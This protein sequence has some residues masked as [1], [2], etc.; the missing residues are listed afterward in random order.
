[1]MRNQIP[2]RDELLSILVEHLKCVI[3]ELPFEIDEIS[4]EKS[5]P[6]SF[7]RLESVYRI[8]LEIR[9]GTLNIDSILHQLERLDLL[10]PHPEL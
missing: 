8:L 7:F 1:M 2:E 3:L 6:N 9:S 10:G 4:P 5:S